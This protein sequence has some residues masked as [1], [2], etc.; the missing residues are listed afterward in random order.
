MGTSFCCAP[1]VPHVPGAGTTCV[2]DAGEGKESTLLSCEGTDGGK[3]ICC[4]N[5][6]RLSSVF[7]NDLA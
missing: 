7:G 5:V 6:S 2:F 1:N 4:F 3:S